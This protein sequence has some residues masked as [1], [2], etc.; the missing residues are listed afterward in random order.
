MSGGVGPNFMVKRMS[1]NSKLNLDEPASPKRRNRMIAVAI[2][3]AASLL[4][5]RCDYSYWNGNGYPPTMQFALRWFCQEPLDG[6]NVY[7]HD[8][9]SFCVALRGKGL[10]RVLMVYPVPKG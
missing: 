6:L 4:G 5:L 8:D 2:V 7:A 9:G 3:L 10:H 1:Y